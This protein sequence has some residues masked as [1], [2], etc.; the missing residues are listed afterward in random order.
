MS[1]GLINSNNRDVLIYT[2]RQNIFRNSTCT[3][4]GDSIAGDIQ[5]NISFFEDD[6]LESIRLLVRNERKSLAIKP[7]VK[8]ILTAN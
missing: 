1:S 5:K 4:E 2:G 7:P 6:S 8:N 3:A